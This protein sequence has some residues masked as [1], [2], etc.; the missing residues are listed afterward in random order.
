ME[1]LKLKK[2]PQHISIKNNSFDLNYNISKITENIFQGDFMGSKDLNQI[3]KIGITH[4]LVAGNLAIFHSN[5]FEYIK[6]DITDDDDEY[7]YKYFDI[8]FEFIDNCLS[9]GGKVLIHCAAGI[10][11]SSTF[12]CCFLIKKLK[13]TPQEALSFIKK[14]RPVASP[15]SGF[16]QQLNTWYDEQV[17]LISVEERLLKFQ[18]NK[19]RKENLEK[20]L[21]SADDDLDDS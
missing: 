3:Q 8:A 17:Q 1:K 16:I 14:G 19:M 9:N 12:T 6:F 4:I 20:F 18:L 5:Y 10:S 21:D 13:I 15:N 7:I 11:R 2:F